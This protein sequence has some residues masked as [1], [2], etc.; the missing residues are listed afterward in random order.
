[1][2]RTIPTL[3]STR[4]QLGVDD[5]RRWTSRFNGL[6]PGLKPLKRFQ[7]RCAPDTGLKPGATERPTTL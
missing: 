4:L 6:F 5:P 7:L 3:I 1:M 2:N